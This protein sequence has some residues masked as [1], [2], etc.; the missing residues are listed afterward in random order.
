MAGLFPGA[1]DVDTFWQNIVNKVDTTAEVPRNRWIVDPDAM[2][3]AA[4]MPDKAYS[5]RACLINDF[6]FNPK[7]IDLDENLLN[8]LDPLH[9]MVVHTGRDALDSC[10]NPLPNKQ[11]TGVVLAAI[12]LPT[13]ASSTISR[14][15]LGT[16][17]EEIL[18]G[19]RIQKAGGNLSRED[20]LA[21]RVTSFPGAIL[22]EGLGLGG[23]N[24]TL[25]AACASSLYAVKLACDELRSHRADAMLAGGVS[26][27]DCLYTQVGFSQ[28]KALSPSGRC[29]PFDESAG[30]LVV[31]EGAG[32]LVLKRLDDAIRDNDHIHA[33]IQGVG[34]ANDMRGN[35]L[36][37]DSEGQVRA[38]RGAYAD[39]GWSP[40]DVDLIECH[41]AGTPVGDAVELQSLRRLW[42]ESGWSQQQCAIGSVKSMIGHLLTGA[43]AAGMI[44]T[45]LAL[46]LNILPPSLNF[47]KAPTNSPLH[48]SPFRVQTEPDHWSRR[49]PD[50]P[51]RAAVSA[52]GFGGI[53]SHLLFEEWHPDFEIH[54]SKRNT[55]PSLTVHHPSSTNTS[56]VEAEP[57]AIIPCR[58]FRKLYSEDNP[59]LSKDPTTAGT[60]ATT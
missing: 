18:L 32:I 27:P 20:C 38:M 59:P 35:L 14:K 7:G 48:N 58:H 34:L 16:A 43:G 13:D 10:A 5:K 40:K 53:N 21:A 46:K 3:C 55:E 42:G 1:P 11:H 9:Q 36:A 44:K 31:G 60:V 54:R 57:V 19:S 26:R 37:P 49:S 29:A 50:K 56:E 8:A 12:A 15:L 25:D 4:P 45:I 51:L 2:V 6:K 39:A 17:F 28:L 41:G 24:Y 22:S 47:T 23:G 30:G 52:F 33:L